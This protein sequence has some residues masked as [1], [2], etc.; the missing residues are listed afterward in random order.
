M[1]DGIEE[2]EL[3]EIERRAAEAF[4]VAPPP[5]VALLETRGGLAGESFI[6]LGDEPVLDHELYL[7]LLLGSTRVASPDVALDAVIDYIAH[8][9]DAIPR[10]IA[11]IRLLRSADHADDGRSKRGTGREPA[12]AEQDRELWAALVDAEREYRRHRADF[13]Q[14]AR[15]RLPILKSALAGPPWQVATALRFLREFSHDA[16]DLLPQIVALSMSTRWALAARQAIDRIPRDRL[17]SALTPIID[18]QVQTTD[19]DDLRRLAELLA[20]VQAWPLLK[21]LATRA[22]DLDDPEARE[23]ADDVTS[24]YPL[25]WSAPPESP[26]H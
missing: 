12:S 19:P 18:M 11:E 4:A 8:A 15:D 21:K 17:W 2:T 1:S 13:Y 25:S 5:W 3:A 22:R 7:T 6:R 14:N 10:L 26:N 24:Q 23:L 20:H 16:P 9:C